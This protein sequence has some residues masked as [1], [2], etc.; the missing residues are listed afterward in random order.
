MLIH[1]GSPCC[2][3]CVLSLQ[4]AKCL[5]SR[6]YES[7]HDSVVNTH[8]APSFPSHIDLKPSSN[9]H[10]RPTAY[11]PCYP[12]AKFCTIGMSYD[13]AEQLDHGGMIFPGRH[14]LAN[15]NPGE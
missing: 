1:L 7:I 10:S 4:L 3:E 9:T 5:S 15:Y 2:A 8:T 11:H 13:P 14:V 12:A 6:A